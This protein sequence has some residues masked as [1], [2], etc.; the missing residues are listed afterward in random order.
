ML[1]LLT[2]YLLVLAFTAAVWP[3]AILVFAG[4]AYG[5]PKGIAFVRSVGAALAKV[6]PTALFACRGGRVTVTVVDRARAAERSLTAWEMNGY[7]AKVSLL[8]WSGPPKSGTRIRKRLSVELV[9]RYLAFIVFVILPVGAA[10]WLTFTYH[11]LWICGA[12]AVTAGAIFSTLSGKMLVPNP[13]AVFRMVSFLFWGSVLARWAADKLSLGW[14]YDWLNYLG[15]LS[16]DWHDR[17]VPAVLTWTIAVVI[18][19]VVLG[20]ADEP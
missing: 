2:H 19:A 13:L 7:L 1:T 14:L 16:A 4:V 3:L 10:M 17:I 15:G 12:V 5:N 18:A 20:W 8:T 6:P 9:L 11:W